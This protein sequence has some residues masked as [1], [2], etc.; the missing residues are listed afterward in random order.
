MILYCLCTPPLQKSPPK[1]LPGSDL[2]HTSY[3]GDRGRKREVKRK[4]KSDYQRLETPICLLYG[5]NFPDLRFLPRS[6]SPLPLLEVRGIE[7]DVYSI[8]D[9][10]RGRAG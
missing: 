2:N 1:K 10:E 8:R 4:R 5:S 3:R 9:W 6:L 7:K